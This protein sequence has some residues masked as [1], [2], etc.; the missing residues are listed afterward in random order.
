VIR[1]TAARGLL[2]LINVKSGTSE[3]VS[4]KYWRI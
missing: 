3:A 2:G 1:I 4:S